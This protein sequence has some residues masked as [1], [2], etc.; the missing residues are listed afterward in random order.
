MKFYMAIL[1]DDIG[2][3]VLAAG[4][5]SRMGSP[6]LLLKW[7]ER[8]VIQHIVQTIHEAQIDKVVV[9]SGR[10]HQALLSE[11][12]N[13]KVQIIQNPQWETGKML[14]S[15]QKGI[16]ALS[17]RSKAVLLCLGDLPGISIDVITRLT[18]AY[19]ENTTSLILPEYKG[20]LGHPVIIPRNYWMEI[21]N[22]NSPIGLQALMLQHK[23]MIKRVPVNTEGILLDIDTPEAYQLARQSL[24]P[25]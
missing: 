20:R 24:L 2:A 10:Y 4:E 12:A 1:L 25:R 13:F 18:Q 22:L 6:K 11:L 17:T 19:Y 15:V 5:S 14:S 9:V 8:T 23:D 21:H 16:S 7:G 3:V